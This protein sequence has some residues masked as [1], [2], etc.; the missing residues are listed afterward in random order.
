MS[1]ATRWGEH[2]FPGI[3]VLTRDLHII[4]AMHQVAIEM[5]AWEP[6]RFAQFQSSA[7]DVPISRRLSD[8]LQPKRGYIHPH[9][10]RQKMSYWQ[11][12]GSLFQHFALLS[13]R[14]ALSTRGYRDLIFDPYYGPVGTDS[15]DLRR[16]RVR[17]FRWYDEH[18]DRFLENVDQQN[19]SAIFK[20]NGGA[21]RRWWLTGIDPPSDIP[22]PIR[23]VRELEFFFTVWQS[24]FEAAAALLHRRVRLPI[25]FSRNDSRI[26]GFVEAVLRV[27]ANAYAADDCSR[28]M[29]ICLSMHSSYIKPRLIRWK[30]E[31]NALIKGH[32]LDRFVG[33]HN[34][35][36]IPEFGQQEGIELL[37]AL[38]ELH[39]T[40]CQLQN[41]SYAISVHSFKRGQRGSKIPKLSAEFTAGHWGLFAYRFEAAC[42]LHHSEKI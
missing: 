10:L 32:S 3:T 30:R 41:K 31:V 7:T 37:E 39:V 26:A 25:R 13:K 11:R 27:R 22:A 36:S 9:N 14:R 42:T 19:V 29:R 17:H 4:Q 28:L 5:S 33:L 34:G 40:Y 2:L 38:A 35:Q 1:I 23:L 16:K 18:R 8:I 15:L 24:L 20:G 6:A 21:W 12:Y